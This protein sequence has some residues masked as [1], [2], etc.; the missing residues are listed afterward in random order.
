MGCG[1]TTSGKLAAKKLGCALLDTDQLIVDREQM[2]IPEIF[3]QKGEPYFRRI[4][5]ET[6]KSLCGR[7]AV[8]ACG[9]G[10]LL[11][12]DTAKAAMDGGIVIFLDVP[13]DIC[14]ERI[15]DD[16]NRPIAAASNRDELLER[17]NKRREIY[18]RNSSVTIDAS[19]TP[20]EIA[21]MIANAVR[22]CN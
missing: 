6:V 15:K 11:N 5:A 7:T 2:S 20:V 14:Y 1:K 10:A 18:S 3:S 16:P 17:Y 4:E 22:D 21:E 12:D 19:G 9:G 8:V 13:F